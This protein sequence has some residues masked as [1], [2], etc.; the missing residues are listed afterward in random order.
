MPRHASRQ[1]P[2]LAQAAELRGHA[3]SFVDRARS[4]RDFVFIC[5][6]PVLCACNCSWLAFACLLSPTDAIF[7][8][9]HASNPVCAHELARTLHSE[10]VAAMHSRN[11]Q[12]SALAATLPLAAICQKIDFVTLAA[13]DCRN[14]ASG[15]KYCKVK[16]ASVGDSSPRANAH[17]G[18]GSS[19]PIQ[20][21]GI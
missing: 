21:G 4:S 12:A 3:E 19:F 10:N 2:G 5:C 8:T 11:R 9:C 6:L 20:N 1:L 13:S 17:S 7:Q 15:Q 16:A 14:I 18:S